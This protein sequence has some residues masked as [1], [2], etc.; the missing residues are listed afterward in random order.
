MQT[1]RVHM[2]FLGGQFTVIAF[3]RLHFFSAWGLGYH[4]V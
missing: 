4:V 2:F 3:I 1:Y